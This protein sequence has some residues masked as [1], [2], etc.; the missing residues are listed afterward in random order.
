M[1]SKVMKLFLAGLLVLLIISLT[2]FLIYALREDRGIGD[3]FHVKGEKTLL[4]SEEYASQDIFKFN[5]LS[6][7]ADVKFVV[8]DTPNLVKVNVYGSKKEEAKVSLNGNVLDISYRPSNFCFGF[9]FDD[10]L[11][12]VVLPSDYAGDIMVNAVSGDVLMDSFDAQ[13]L[14]IKTVSG[15]VKVGDYENLEIETVSGDVNVLHA[16]NL[17]VKTISGEISISSVANLLDLSTTSG[18]IDIKDIVLLKNSKIKTVSGDVEI[19]RCNNIYVSSKTVSGDVDIRYNNRMSDVEL[20]I[21]TT[22]GDIE[23]G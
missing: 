10:S 23:I 1:A 21:T 18:D 13:N 5:V 2:V 11:I 3:I 22:S 7:E 8:G 15:E 4:A 17:K 19:E 14:N 9:C 6:K 20:N 12:E 16:D